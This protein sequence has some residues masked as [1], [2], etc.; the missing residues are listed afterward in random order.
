MEWLSLN[1]F[2]Q[3]ETIKKDSFQHPVLIFKHSTRCSVS[4]VAKSRLERAETPAGIDFYFLDLLAHR[5]LSNEVAATFSVYHESPQVLLIRR[6]ECIYD[7]SHSSIDMTDI[8]EQA[9]Q[10]SL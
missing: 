2:N 6:G 1:D 10:V 9:T 5:A 3:L 4:H 7:E 8:L